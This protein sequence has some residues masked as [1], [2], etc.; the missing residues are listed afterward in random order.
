VEVHRHATAHDLASSAATLI[1]EDCNATLEKRSGAYVLG[2]SGGRTPV[3]MFHCL[4]LLDLPWS[5][6]HVF[7]VDE[8]VAPSRSDDRNFTQ[9]TDQLLQRVEIP[10]ENVHPMPVESNDL[11]SACRCY[12]DELAHVTG[13]A[14]LDFIQLGLGDD[15]H[16]ASLAPGDPILDMID[17]DIWHVERF[18]GLSRM[19]MTYRAINRANRVLWL[20]TGH[21]KAEMCRRLLAGDHAIPAGRVTPDRAILFADEA[22]GANL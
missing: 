20:A 22:A 16:T 17:R 4:A 6:I 3:L 8:R 18:N 15:G 12:E 5:R 10:S 7:Q 1:L 2:L 11:A 14:P 9:L 19:S 13:G 21:A